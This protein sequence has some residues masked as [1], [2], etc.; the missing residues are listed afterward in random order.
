MT[1]LEKLQAAIQGSPELDLEVMKYLGSVPKRA[2][3]SN[4]EKNAWWDNGCSYLAGSVSSIQSIPTTPYT[5]SVDAAM[6]VIPEG[7]AILSMWNYGS[8]NGGDTMWKVEMFSGFDLPD[9][10]SPDTSE[11]RHQSLPIAILITAIKAREV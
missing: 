1:I 2:E 10:G 7:W 4:I 9:G 3:L 6:S 8:S 11:G 5:T